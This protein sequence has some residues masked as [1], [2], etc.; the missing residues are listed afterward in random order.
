MAASY[1]N[2]EIDLLELFAKFILI[3]R[4]NTVII[5]IAFILGTL[6]GLAYYQFVPKSY[7]SRMILTSD[8]LTE[9]YSKTLFETINQLVK[10]R[11]T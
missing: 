3:I 6:L 10:E 9:S 11:N 2:D 1:Q 4:R 7:E 5:I 8:I